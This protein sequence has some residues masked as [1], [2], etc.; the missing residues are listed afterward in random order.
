V[1]AVLQG[2][3]WNAVTPLVIISPDELEATIARALEP[4]LREVARLKEQRGDELL[5]I[6]EVASMLRVSPRSVQRWVRAGLLPA[7]PAGRT[8]RIRRGALDGFIPGP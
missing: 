7:V 1:R 5:S 3:N 8:H 4:V 2:T 6:A